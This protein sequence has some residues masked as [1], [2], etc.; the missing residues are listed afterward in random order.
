MFRMVEFLSQG[1]TLRGRLYLP[2]GALEPSPVVIMAHGFS[3]TI[4]GMAADCYAEVFQEAGMAVLL[5]DHRNFGLSDGEPRQEIN[6]WV[7]ARGYRD[8]I[9]YLVTLPGIDPGRI[10]LW[11][12]SLSGAETIMVGAVDARVGAVVAQVPAC[13]D[14][15]A[16]LDPDGQHFALIRETFLHADLNGEPRVTLGPMPVVSFDPVD[17]PCL[18]TPLTAFRWFIEYGGRY[19]T[20]WENRASVVG[21]TVPMPFH[22]GL[23][24]PH[25]KAPLLMVIARED[26]MPGSNSG[27]ARAVLDA[28]AAPKELM[29]IDGGH[30]GLLHYPSLLFDEVSHAQVDFLNRH[31]VAAPISILSRKE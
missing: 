5:Y 2:P 15:A 25:L 12:D 4:S 8:A 17:V 20:G 24:S 31:L 6:K 28:A 3:A 18:L 29:E 30:F 22:A 21:P 23:C 1:A 13:G 10:A 26:E 14:R 27:I 16:P 7:Q 19:G 9:D 11:G